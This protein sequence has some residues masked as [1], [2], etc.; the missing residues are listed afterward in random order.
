MIAVGARVV[1]EAAGSLVSSA[2]VVA[3]CHEVEIGDLVAIQT[4]GACF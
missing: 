4:Y 2:E 3:L 1:D